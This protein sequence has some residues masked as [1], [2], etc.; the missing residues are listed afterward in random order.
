MSRRNVAAAV[1]L[2]ALA[3]LAAVLALSVT[4]T[5]IPTA[6]PSPTVVAQTA[7]PTATTTSPSPAASPTTSSSSSG[8]PGPSAS[9]GAIYNDDFGF[10]VTDLG[11][12]PTIQAS[13]TANIRKES[14]NAS[15]ASFVHEGFWVS[16]DGTQIAYWSA[17]TPSELSQLRIVRAADPRSLVA[18]SGL[19]ADENGGF[20]VWANDSSG[21]AYVIHGPGPSR[22]STVTS[23]I[24]TF[25]TRPGNSGP[26]QVVMQFNEAG[27]SITPIA[28]DRA[29]D[30]L[31]VGVTATAPEG[32]LTEYIVAST[33]TPQL[34]PK[35]APVTARISTGTVRASSDAKL[36]LGVTPGGDIYWWPIDNV[37]A[38]RTALSGLAGAG[39]RGALWRPGTH[40]IGYIAPDGHALNDPFWLGDVDK[41][42]TQ[43]LCCVAFGSVP[44][45]AVVRAFRADGSAVLLAVP[46]GSGAPTSYTLVRFASDPKSTSGDRVTFSSRRRAHGLSK[47]SLARSRLD[48]LAFGSA[49]T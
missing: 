35:R 31:A 30:Q 20:I 37:A 36:V 25:N 48:H 5:E 12:A 41:A 18:S 11:T 13:A 45:G 33:A 1:G 14:N 10:I 16:P 28:W 32:F 27:K 24:R 9:G 15:F 4:R 39:K 2:L 6:S 19:S 17:R 44:D 47:G 43:N 26:G 40:Q 29:A 34:D 49:Y 46:G 22:P 8:P 23:T 42:G 3:A 21:V 38:I 7:A